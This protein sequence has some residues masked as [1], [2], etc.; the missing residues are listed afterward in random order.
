MDSHRNEREGQ[1]AR[2][3]ALAQFAVEHA[4]LLREPR[5]W[6]RMLTNPLSGYPTNP[7]LSGILRLYEAFGDLL[8]TRMR[9]ASWLSMKLSRLPD[10]IGRR[11]AERE[12][13]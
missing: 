1:P 2:T 6:T 3:Q 11:S 13:G 10:R 5:P 4:R 12:C 9:Q 8:L 7:A